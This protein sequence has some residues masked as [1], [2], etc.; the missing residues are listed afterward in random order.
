[1]VMTSMIQ[2]LVAEGQSEL[3]NSHVNTVGHDAAY[4]MPYKTLKKMMTTKYCPKG[5]IKKLEIELWNL[6]FKGTNV[7]SY[8]QRFQELALMC[9]RIFPKEFDEVEKYVSGLPDMIQGR[10]NPDS[11]VVT[12]TFLLNN[13]YA[14]ILFNTSADRIFVS[15]TFSSLIDIIPTTL[16]RD[17]EVELADEIDSFDVIIGMDWLSKYHAVII[18]DKKIDRIPFGN[19]ILIVHVVLAH[20]TTKKTEDKSEEKR[21][22]DV[23][24]VRDFPKVFLE[25]LPAQ[26]PY[27]LAPS[28]MKELLDQLPELSDKGFIRP[29]SSPWGA[30]LTVKNRYP[31]PR[32]DDLIRLNSRVECLIEDRLEVE[33]SSTESSANVDPAEIEYIKDWTSPKTAMEIRQFLGLA[34]YYRRFIEGFSKIAKSMTKLTQKKVKFDWDDKQEAAFQLLKEKLCSAPI[35]ALPEGAENFIVYYD[36]SHKG[37]VIMEYLVNISK[38]RAFWSLNEDILKINDSD[39]QYA[40]S[41]KEDTAYPCLHSPKTTKETSSIRRIQRRSIRRIEDIELQM[42]AYHRWIHKDVIN[43]IV[44]VLKMIHSIYI[45]GVDSHKLRMKI[46]PLSLADEAKQWWINEGEGKITIW[47]ELIEKFFCKFYPESYDGEEEMLDEGDNWEIDPLEF[48]SRVNSSFDKHM[49]MDR[50]NKKVLFHAWV[51]GIW[52]KR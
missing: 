20:I 42:N 7:L 15:T 19:E 45:P 38:R 4:E 34:G 48:I 26:A 21:L 37:L 31:L 6:K 10:T 9:W 12:G 29:S 52:N 25:D 43:H 14:L 46:F 5:E 39:N 13:R 8:N 51:N 49:K 36:A 11:N 17:Y 44:M 41:I 50:R 22:E 24:I 30:Q 3:L 1:M 16:D 33:L 28:Q 18:C 40:V 23:P 32:I 47:E 27:R 2:E 35:L